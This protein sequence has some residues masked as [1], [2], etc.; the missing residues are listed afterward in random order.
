MNKYLIGV[1]V[2]LVV[3][4]G[5]SLM[6]NSDDVEVLSDVVIYKSLSCGCCSVY[7]SYMSNKGYQVEQVNTE[8][9]LSVKEK[10]G[11]PNSLQSCHTSEVEGYVVEGHVPEEAI[12]KLLTESPDIKGIGMAGMPSGSPGMS[13]PKLGDFVIYEITHEGQKGDIFMSI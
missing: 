11:I 4:V 9:M 6:I 8:N 1:L 12:R 10:F 7:S 2:I 5:G 3:I 13:G